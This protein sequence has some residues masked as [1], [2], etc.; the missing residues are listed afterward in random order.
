MV[1]T[2]HRTAKAEE[3]DAILLQA[4][5]KLS[6][7]DTGNTTITETQS[8]EST[9]VGDTSV[10]SPSSKKP[11]STKSLTD[12]STRVTKRGTRQGNPKHRTSNRSSSQKSRVAEDSETPD[13]QDVSSVAEDVTSPMEETTPL[14]EERLPITP[15]QSTSRKTRSRTKKNQP[16]SAVDSK[17]QVS[18]RVQKEESSKKQARLRTKFVIKLASIP[19]K[20][21]DYKT[22]KSWDIRRPKLEKSYWPYPHHPGF[23][24]GHDPWIHL[25]W[26][27]PDVEQIRKV[28]KLLTDHHKKFDFGSYVSMPA[29]GTEAKVTIDAIFQTLFAQSTDNEIAIDTHSR[30]CNAFPYLVNGKKYVGKMPNWH[31]IRLLERDELPAALQQGGFHEMRARFVKDI[32][33]CVYQKNV[34]RK[35]HGIQQYEHDGNPPNAKDF[36]PGMLSMDWLTDEEDNSDEAILGRLIQLSGIGIK[37]AM[38]VMA[39]SMKRPLFVVD[40]HVLRYAQ[41]LGWVPKDATN[42]DWVA[43]YLHKYVPDDIKYDLHNQIWTHCANE[44]TKE[45]KTRAVICPFCGA[46]PPARNRDVSQ[47]TCPLADLLPPLET[48]WG[49]AYTLQL[50][51]EA[52]EAAKI[53]TAHAE[54]NEDQN[55]AEGSEIVTMPLLKQASMRSFVH[56]LPTPPSSPLDPSLDFVDV[57]KAEETEEPE[58]ATSPIL[59]KKLK[60]L[61]LKAKSHRFE[62]ISKEQGEELTAAGYYLWE[63]RPMDNTFME[64]WGTFEKKPRYKWERDTVM[65]KDVAVTWEYAND[66]LNNDHSHKWSRPSANEISTDEIMA[67]MEE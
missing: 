21:L 45:S 25:N 65:D 36:V 37:S 44:N 55:S 13:I 9:H 60:K 47:H 34:D 17:P 51:Q 4:I 32:L 53:E 19:Y 26:P 49:K 61:N 39:F 22:L 11:T 29:H 48:R 50:R 41:W 40:V 20:Q 16:A 14:V 56:G 58:E 5:L 7:Y 15:Q 30:L 64:E 42:V 38:C 57:A 23:K 66:V 54:N 2:R 27:A 6:E 12:N 62:D 8:Q 33:D 63:F 28:H 46:R 24:L 67:T 10:K 35:L 59:K 43:M 1:Y 18:G 31:D 52:R 3:E